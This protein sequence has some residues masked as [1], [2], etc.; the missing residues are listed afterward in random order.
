MLRFLAKRLLLLVPILLVV[1]MLVFLVLRLG[2]NDPAMSYLRL[3]Q[4]PPTDEALATARAHLGLDRPLPIQYLDWLWKALHLDFGV[5]YV[6]GAPVLDRLLY[7]L[8]NTLELA[9]ISLL[10]TMGFSLLLGIL[11]ALRKDRWLDHLVRVLAFLGVS[12]PS[13]WLGFL[14]VF[15]FSVQLRW[16]PPLGIGGLSHIVMP[17]FTLSLM[18]LCINTR[19]I[20]GSI[21]EQMNTR[22][23]LYARIR[24]IPEKWIMGR[25]VL[26]NSLIPV[27]TALGMHIGE[28]LGGAVVVEVIFAWPGAGRYA[29]SAIHNRDFP[30]MQCFILLMTV[31]FVCCNLMVDILC[32]WI[33]PRL[34]MGEVKS[35]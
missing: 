15:L 21:L 6:T 19:F 35:P 3:S 34:R 25:H 20:R 4:I 27:V 11:S 26:R 12:T 16:L 9:G 1:S 33:D 10:F 32:T 8:P 30:V 29:M 23:I 7:F 13:F 5:S 17:A 24:G 22:S 28:L 18:S 14:L 31:I 2:D